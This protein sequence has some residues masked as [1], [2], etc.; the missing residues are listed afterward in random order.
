MDWEDEEAEDLVSRLTNEKNNQY[1][2][3]NTTTRATTTTLADFLP[4]QQQQQVDE[5]SSS[6]S[7][8]NNNKKTGA[9]YFAYDARLQEAHPFYA[10]QPV[11]RIL[12]KADNSNNNTIGNNEPPK[13]VE[14]KTTEELLMKTLEEREREYAKA[15][16]MIFSRQTENVPSSAVNQTNE[17]RASEV[18]SGSNSVT[19]TKKMMT[20]ESAAAVPQRAPTT[21]ND[22]RKPQRGNHN[23]GFTVAAGRGA[24]N[25]AV[26]KK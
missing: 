1:G 26:A 12:K 23:K 10:S 20:T 17:R 3:N 2:N 24:R 25:A 9:N 19:K 14:Q 21:C 15:R 8:S 18:S 22:N 7:S 5:G 6:S 13:T 4:S 11:I 16:E